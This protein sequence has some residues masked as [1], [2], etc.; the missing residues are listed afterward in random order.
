MYVHSLDD[1]ED[2]ANVTADTTYDWVFAYD[3]EV[4]PKV[5]LAVSDITLNEA[6]TTD[7]VTATAGEYDAETGSITV[8]VA[9]PAGA[10]ALTEYAI[11]AKVTVGESDETAS[12]TLT[13]TE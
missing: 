10:V 7:G 3:D 13:V 4:D 8:A 2:S 6:A 12:V 11:G 5:A 1:Y 9:I